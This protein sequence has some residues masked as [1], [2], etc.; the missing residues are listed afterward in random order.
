MPCRV[1]LCPMK[2]EAYI[3]SAATLLSQYDGK[4]PFASWQ[5]EYFRKEKKFGSRDRRIVSQLCFGYFRSGKLFADKPLEE[6]IRLASELA[7]GDSPLPND[8]SA[9]FPLHVHLSEEIHAAAF[10]KSHLQQ[11]DLFLRARPG[12]KDAV[13]FKLEAGGIPFTECSTDCLALLNGSKVEEV[14]VL[15][16][17][18]VVQDRSSQQVLEPMQEVLPADVRF[19]LWDCCAASGG[20]SILAL[21]RF[22]KVQLTVSDVRESILHNLRSRFRR[23]RISNYRSFLADVS[24]SQFSFPHQF[25]VVLCDAPCSGSGTWGRTPEQLFYFTAERIDHYAS[26]QRRIAHNAIKQVKKGGFF[27]YITCSVFSAENEENVAFIQ[28]ESGLTLLSARYYKGY[29]VRADTLF[30]AL[31]K[32]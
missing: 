20:K 32:A 3:R 30:A 16:E 17:E 13:K 23:A 1:H 22:P 28:K 18:A 10:I 9:V 19:T 5:K 11:P 26:L 8:L 12:R 25:D 31:F 2:V 4:V 15:D 6:G 24:A 27:L 29:E 21:D 7:T 14:I